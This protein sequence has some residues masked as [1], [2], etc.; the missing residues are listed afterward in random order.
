MRCVRIALCTFNDESPTRSAKRRR[1]LATLVAAC[2]LGL[3]LIWMALDNDRL[4]WHDRISRMY[5][6]AY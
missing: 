3:G 4:G 6:R 5:P 2:P 1:I